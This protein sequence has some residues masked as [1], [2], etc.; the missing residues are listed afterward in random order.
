MPT[1]AADDDFELRHLK[2]VRST[3][4]FEELVYRATKAVP[5]GSV[6]TYGAIAKALQ[7]RS[8]QAVGQALKRNPFAPVV[9]C[10]RVISTSLTIGGFCG[11]GDPKRSVWLPAPTALSRLRVSEVWTVRCRR[12]QRGDRAQGGAASE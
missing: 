3:T 8:S 12:R 6:T 1:P 9:P 4:P 7:C 10:H 5:A 11:S 2:A